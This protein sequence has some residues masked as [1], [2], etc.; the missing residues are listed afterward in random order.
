MSEYYHVWQNVLVGIESEVSRANFNTWFKDTCIEKVDRGT[1]TIGV[2]S[3]FI[4]E[5]LSDHYQKTIIKALR[6]TLPDVRTVEYVISKSKPTAPASHAKVNPTHK[7]EMVPAGG[8]PQ[9]LPLGDLYVDKKTQLN[10][11]YTFDDFIIGSF[12]ELAYSASQ[13][14][15][16][17]PGVYNPLFIY[18]DTGLGKTH[19]IQAIGN[20]L[21]QRY[22]G[23]RVFY[24]SSQQYV[25]TF[26]AAIKKG[27]DAIAKMKEQYRSYDCLIMDDIQF[28]SNRDKSQEELFHI[29]NILHDNNK[30]IIF[31]SDKHPNYIIGLED[32]LKSRFSAGMII[33]ITKPDYESRMAMIQAKLKE[34]GSSLP[35]PVIDYVAQNVDGSIRELEGVLNTL[36]LSSQYEN[37][38]LEKAKEIIK[39]SVRSKKQ[40]SAEDI[41]HVVSRFYNI[42]H[43]LI[44]DK[45]RRKEVVRARQI[46]MYLLR[47]D[48]SISFPHI[49]R[50]L[51]GRD[52]TTVIHSC[53]KVADELKE[54][55]A[56]GQEIEEI[57]SMLQTY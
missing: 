43:S 29:F 33:D 28:L 41:V 12:N 39:N 52:H 21:L 34:Q 6:T 42:D 24:T 32:R 30:Q 45:T 51:G 2:P 57:R 3:D 36:V 1:V 7:K 31:S 35:D 22:A 9:E 56:L 8:Q 55:P 5:W 26:V 17:K 48:Y 50:E 54:S 49:G 25:E 16:K 15:L 46:V 13:A 37:L 53:N 40:I 4:R 27:Q 38:G 20:A 11:K 18:G 23:I 47:E 14:I 10:P 19:L 44:Y